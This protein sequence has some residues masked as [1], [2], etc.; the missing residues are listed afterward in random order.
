MRVVGKFAAAFLAVSCVCLTLFGIVNAR[1]EVADI[2][3]SVT[4]DLR[5]FGEEL[6]AGIAASWEAG[7]AE[8]A[9]DVLRG[10]ASVKGSVEL[11]WLA[12]GTQSRDVA[13]VTD[14]G[15]GVR[16]VSVELPVQVDGKIVGAL[17]LRRPIY[18]H[19]ARLRAAVLEELGLA[20]VLAIGGG[21][22]AVSLGVV[23]IG[24][25]LQRIVAQ[26]RRIG[27]GDFSQR[28]RADGTD[29][30]GA[31]KRELN[32]MCDQLA[33]ART[34]LEDES[35][36]RVETLEQLRHLDRLRTVGTLASSLAHE[37][38][39]PLNVLLLRGE[40]L[41]SGELGA[42]DVTAT[43]KTIAGQVKKMS[44]IV[45]QLLDFSRRAPARGEVELATVARRAADLLGSLAKKN[46]VGFRV[47]IDEDVTVR[48]D[49]GQLE[50]AV[51][52]LIVNGVQ[53]MPGGGEIGLR[54]GVDAAAQGPGRIEPM[55]AAF[56][57]VRDQGPGVPPEH[58]ARIFEP[59]Y[60][61]KPAGEGTGL[62][63]SVA[64]G[65]AEEHG[66]W[67]AARSGAEG[68]TAFTIYLPRSK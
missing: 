52:N 23:L 36:A 10:A 12:A 2:E 45:R 8:K 15:D 42:E 58:L 62:G 25:P 51:T 43:G 50:Q 11:R 57:E 19:R 17:A 1:R 24:R 49:A 67:I 18:D 16:V 61:T 41:A 53:A 66:G 28:L 46:K 33:A 56:L 22:L 38:G 54:V 48:G 35:A 5:S 29:E 65:I 20:A 9:T 40:S 47:T 34:R 6:R 4:A 27:D 7:G 14:E 26:A 55:R 59:F 3:E 37:L 39:T 21:L 31:L 63:L 30:L 68:G 32:A 64:C 60:T 44:R 13:I